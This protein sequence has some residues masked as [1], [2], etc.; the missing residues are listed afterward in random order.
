VK[1]LCHT[2]QTS[3]FATKPLVN[4]ILDLEYPF[5]TQWFATW[6]KISKHPS[7]VVL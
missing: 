1:A 4:I 7:F 2:K 3:Y 5:A 6:W